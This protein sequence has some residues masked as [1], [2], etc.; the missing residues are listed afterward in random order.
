[1]PWW[2]AV[3]PA[4]LI[5][6]VGS[7]VAIMNIPFFTSIAHVLLDTKDTGSAL[8]TSAA[9]NSAYLFSVYALYGLLVPLVCTVIFCALVIRHKKYRFLLLPVAVV[10]PLWAY[11]LFPH[12]SSDHPWMLRRFVFALLP[13]TFLVSTFLVAY[14][15]QRFPRRAW[16]QYI[17]VAC[18]LC[19]NIPAWITF[20]PYAQHTTL[21]RQIHDIARQFSPRDLVLIDKDTTGDGWAMMTG[22]LRT[23]YNVHAVYFFNVADYA[24]IDKTAY[25]HIY[26][27]TPNTKRDFYRDAFADRLSY[28]GKCTIATNRL[29]KIHGKIIPRNF[30]HKQQYVIRNTIYELAK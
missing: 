24:Q 29:E 18:I 20:L 12:I 9:H 6:C 23:Q 14:L 11:Y 2:H 22:V 13:A 26:L 16:V 25:N 21:H 3:F 17:I 7:L 30:P 8:A 5:F 15:A 27:I 10:L 4:T 1:H 28:H 19:T